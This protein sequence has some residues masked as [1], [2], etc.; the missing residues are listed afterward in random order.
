MIRRIVIFLICS[1]LCYSPVYSQQRVRD[2]LNHLCTVSHDTLKVQ[3]LNKI[4]RLLEG[5]NPDSAY[6]F[7]DSA[8]VLSRK[9]NYDYGIGISYMSMGSSQTTSGKYDLA[10]NDL[11]KG[12]KILEKVKNK[13]ALTNI[14]NSI[15][16]AYLGLK[17][18]KR[19]YE[20]FLKSHRL[21]GQAPRNDFMVAVTSVGIGGILLEEGKF[22]Q[23]ID[24]YQNAE[25][26]FRDNNYASYGAMASA[27]MGEA[28]YKSGDLFKAEKYYRKVI[29][30]F[31]KVNDEY[32]LATVLNSLG[33]LEMQRKNYQQATVYLEESFELNKKRNA[34]DNIQSAALSLSQAHELQNK[35]AKALVYY[36]V[37]MQYKDSVINVE[38][39]RA[40]AEA[41]SKYESEKKEKELKL[42]NMELESSQMQVSQRNNLIY[43]FAA[44]IVIFIILLFGVYKQFR[45]KRKANFLLQSKNEEVER[46]KS[47]IEEKNK[48]IT[49]SI[50]YSRHIQQAILPSPQAIQESFPD[51]F[52]IFKPKD[53][54]SGDFY[55][56]EKQEEC[57]YL[58]VVDCTGH[59]VPGAML[60]VF[61]HSALKNIISSF[62]LKHNPA[63]ILKELCHQFKT[64]L[65]SN[66]PSLSINDGVD[67]GICIFHP[68]KKMLY[69][70][71]A[72]NNL[73]RIK[74][75]V[76]D[77]FTGN[78][79]GISGTNTGI[80]TEFTDYV[81]DVEISDR[82]YL[83]TDG[84]AD[85]FGGPKGKKFK[86]KQLEE[87]L[88]SN[89][90]LS[91]QQ[92]GE[93]LN[94]VFGN[95]KG[96]LEQ[97][98]DVTLIGFRT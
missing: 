55:L 74:N 66:D 38:R 46:Q 12:L 15:A 18:N 35:P 42:K 96:Q 92:Q 44:A 28:Y 70:A 97:L 40:I 67:M 14:Y 93:S 37:Y 4:S 73:L 29:S 48:D 21:A 16:N 88:L 20:F 61:A 22:V 3:L 77:E 76:K 68:V 57:T 98:D 49:D 30:E 27:M 82:Y 81:I 79:Y 45:E 6:I 69:F 86:Q 75:G 85:Q 26:W 72:K 54:V 80:Q 36:K 59:G 58:A 39:N 7:G 2:S 11:M 56:L 90:T 24:Y 87:T 13:R 52:V 94:T 84:F 33:T 8:L 23:A 31:R 19:A 95:W 64:N 50:N 89:S 32:G 83:F 65:Q 53:I 25:A 47:I 43:V 71:G 10:I 1:F 5:N 60:S 51:S 9:I 78:R 17:N 63:G 41:E 34:L 91:F 62:D